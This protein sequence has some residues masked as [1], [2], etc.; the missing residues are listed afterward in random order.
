MMPNG[1][2]MQW[3]LRNWSFLQKSRVI[4]NQ[5]ADWCGNL[6]DRR[7]H[8]FDSLKRYGIATGLRPSQ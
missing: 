6:V 7:K 2:T 1:F 5:S 4:A 3:A 8:Q